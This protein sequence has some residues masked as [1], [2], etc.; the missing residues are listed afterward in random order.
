MEILELLVTTD[1]L[2]RSQAVNLVGPPGPA[3][4]CLCVV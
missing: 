2:T 1:R 4:W 3:Q